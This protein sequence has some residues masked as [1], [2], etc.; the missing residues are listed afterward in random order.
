[1]MFDDTPS[2]LILA[3]IALLFVVLLA[4]AVY[5]TLQW[6]AFATAHHC[7][8]VQQIAPSTSTGYGYGI[9]SNGQSGYGVITVT[10]PGKTGYACDDGVVYWR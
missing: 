1:M 2:R 9:Q 8:V 3:G 7:K 6:N 5:D 10:Q 4:Y